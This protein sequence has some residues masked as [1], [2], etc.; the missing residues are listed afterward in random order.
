M[1]LAAV[2]SPIPYV[3]TSHA[4]AQKNF[5]F[6][7]LV[8]DYLHSVTAGIW[9]GGLF[10]LGWWLGQK[11]K[12]QM[13]LQSDISFKVVT[14]FSCFAMASTVLIGISGIITAYLNGITLSTL[15][16]SRYGLLLVGKFVFFSCALGAAAVNQFI[17]LRNWNHEAEPDFSKALR[18]EVTVE[19][20]FVIIIFM[21]AG[22]LA[23]TSLPIV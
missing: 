2:L 14:R 16:Q 15:T 10:A 9:T 12:S 23:R 13:E 22:F 7:R 3:L 4:A 5:V 8:L 1:I 19:L 21:I 20:F 6:V 18:R 17:H 11:I